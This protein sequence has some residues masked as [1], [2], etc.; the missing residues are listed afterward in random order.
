MELSDAI[1]FINYETVPYKAHAI[2]ADLGCGSGMFTYALANVLKPGSSIYAIDKIISNWQPQINTS[3]ILIH[4]QQLDFVSEELE[5][6]GLD[7]ILMANSLHYVENKVAL[8]N[9]LSKKL[10][11]D[12]IFLLIEYDTAASN[13]WVPFPVSF[14]SLQVIFKKA[15]YSNVEKLHEKSSAF[16]RS[17]LYSVCIKH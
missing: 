13:P 17:N 3:K 11:D 2:W 16:G 4:Q 7:G 10:N 15:G 1:N 6:P 12:G 9:K 14:N 8:V 5:L